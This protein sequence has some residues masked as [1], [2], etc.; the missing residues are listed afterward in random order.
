MHAVSIDIDLSGANCG[1]QRVLADICDYEN[2]S[3]E[4]KHQWG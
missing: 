3:E 2:R 4:K 1:E